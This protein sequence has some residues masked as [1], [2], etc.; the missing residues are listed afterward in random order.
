[1][2]LGKWAETFFL[3]G[4]GVLTLVVLQIIIFLVFLPSIYFGKGS[5]TNF[6]LGNISGAISIWHESHL[7]IYRR[8]SSVIY[9]MKVGI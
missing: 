1:M 8:I 6:T 5:I 7:A 3:G 9:F 4:G 2:F